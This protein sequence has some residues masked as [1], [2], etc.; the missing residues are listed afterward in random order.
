MRRGFASAELELER[1][2]EPWQTS[3]R[4]DRLPN[5]FKKIWRRTNRRNAPAAKLLSSGLLFETPIARLRRQ[6]AALAG[7]E[8]ENWGNSLPPSFQDS[9]EFWKE[10]YDRA[11]SSERPMY[12]PGSSDFNFFL[13]EADT[14]SESANSRKSCRVTFLPRVSAFNFSYGT[15]TP[16]RRKIV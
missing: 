1:L 15:S 16:S 14:S 8:S 12:C 5:R 4:S 13:T 6:S 2:G 9:R 7:G 10:G 11:T 3:E